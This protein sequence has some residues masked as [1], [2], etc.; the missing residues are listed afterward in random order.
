M[1]SSI[2]INL[3][4]AIVVK[5]QTLYRYSVIHRLISDIKKFFS[6]SFKNSLSRRF[7]NNLEYIYQ[8]S[9][10]SKMS[11]YLAKKIDYIFDIIFNRDRN[12]HNFKYTNSGFSIFGLNQ[13]L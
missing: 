12:D 8:N 6:L 1:Y 10:I 11:E 3:I 13:K 7:F 4:M 2:F 9:N 5:V